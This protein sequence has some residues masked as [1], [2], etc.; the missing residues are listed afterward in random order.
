VISTRNQR[1]QNTAKST[2]KNQTSILTWLDG[3]GAVWSACQP[4]VYHSEPGHHREKEDCQH[5]RV[6]RI[7]KSVTE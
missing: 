6:F 1:T 2:M 4:A 7:D 5:D 3:N